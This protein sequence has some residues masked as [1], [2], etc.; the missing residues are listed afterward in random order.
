MKGEYIA[1]MKR[2][3]GGIKKETIVLARLK[4]CPDEARRRIEDTKFQRET[5]LQQ[6]LG[7][8]P[9]PFSPENPKPKVEKRNS[10][11]GSSQTEIHYRLRKWMVWL[12]VTNAK[13]TAHFI[14]AQELTFSEDSLQLS[15]VFL[16]FASIATVRRKPHAHRTSMGHPEGQRLE[17]WASRPSVR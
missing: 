4:P 14:T 6:D 3:K 16:P 11:N 15:G 8:M 13:A 7:L 17:A 9:V 2:A 1:R 5:R 10:T 12:C